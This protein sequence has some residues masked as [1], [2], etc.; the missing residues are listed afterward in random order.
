RAP[1]GTLPQLDPRCRPAQHSTLLFDHL[2]GTGGTRHSRNGRLWNI[3]SGSASVRLDV[4]SPD[5]LTP[6]LGFVGDELAEVAGRAWKHSASKVSKARL[7]L[8]VG[9]GGVDFAIELVD[10]FSWR[11]SWCCDAI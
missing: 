7:H 11:I 6:L 9:E 3:D 5:H 8:G 4:E 2:V 1:R 10:V